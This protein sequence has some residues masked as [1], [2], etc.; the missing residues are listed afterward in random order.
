LVVAGVLVSDI[1]LEAQ[2]RDYWVPA[3]ADRSFARLGSCK[4]VITE[5]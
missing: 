3:P 5:L 2:S 4:W 1:M